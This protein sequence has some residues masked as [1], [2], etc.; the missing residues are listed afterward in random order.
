M[1]I[2]LSEKFYFERQTKYEE[3]WHCF[4]GGKNQDYITGKRNNENNVIEEKV[5][6]D[7]DKKYWKKKNE[8]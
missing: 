5:W 4:K 3:S 6:E 1:F 8:R 7:K 2:F